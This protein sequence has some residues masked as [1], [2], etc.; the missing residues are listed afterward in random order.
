L[1]KFQNISKKTKKKFLFFKSFFLIDLQI[2]RELLERFKTQEIIHLK[3]IQNNFENELKHGTKD[4]SATNVFNK[5]DDENKR[6]KDFKAR[7]VE[8]VNY[9]IFCF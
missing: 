9:L 8:H 6:W 4:D 3:D 5:I 1:N 2:N 7:V